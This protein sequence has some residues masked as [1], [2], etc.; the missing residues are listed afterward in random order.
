MWP[1]TGAVVYPP[2]ARMI[3]GAIAPNTPAQ[4]PSTEKPLMNDPTSQNSRPLITKMNSPSV[5]KVAGKVGYA[6]A[7]T[8]ETDNSGWL[9]A[10]AWA[11]PKTTKKA[12][13]ANHLAEVTPSPIA[14]PIAGDVNA[15]YEAREG[16]KVT[17]VDTLTVSVLAHEFQINHTTIQFENVAC[18]VAHG[19]VIPVGEQHEHSH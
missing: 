4:K 16:M 15:F 7:P 2:A 17:F 5:S 10:W 6:F 18:E 11:M 8:K 19:C 14:L 1:G 3:S 12:D 13:A 9:W